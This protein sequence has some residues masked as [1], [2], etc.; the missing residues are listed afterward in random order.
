MK[1]IW[2]FFVKILKAYWAL[3]GPPKTDEERKEW[4]DYGF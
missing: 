1:G 3:T 2:R 4:Q